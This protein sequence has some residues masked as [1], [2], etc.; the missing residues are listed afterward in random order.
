MHARLAG[1]QLDVRSYRL[2]ADEQPLGDPFLTEAVREQLKD[3]QFAPR[4]RALGEAGVPR[5]ASQQPPRP[6][7]SLSDL[8]ESGA[9]RS[10]ST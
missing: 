10:A 3:L 8:I 7:R 5:A 2:R 4:E 9:G 6:G 1:G